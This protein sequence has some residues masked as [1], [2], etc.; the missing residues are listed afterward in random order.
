MENP[1]KDTHDNAFHFFTDRNNIIDD[2]TTIEDPI[3]KHVNDDWALYLIEDPE[4]NELSAVLFEHIISKHSRGWLLRNNHLTFE[5]EEQFD[6]LF[7]N[8][9]FAAFLTND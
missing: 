8:G 5:S 7:D 1:V 2:E 4:I 9:D 3:R 6:Q